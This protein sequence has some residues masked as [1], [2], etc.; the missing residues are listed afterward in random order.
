[1]RL[2]TRDSKVIKESKEDPAQMERQETMANKEGLA[3]AV[4]LAK[5]EEEA[6]KATPAFRDL[7]V[8][9]DQSVSL[10]KKAHKAPQD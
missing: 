4:Q 9:K 1:M 2:E 8:H 3:H 10:V 6:I 7:K 5:K